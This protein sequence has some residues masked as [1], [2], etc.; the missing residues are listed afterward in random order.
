[1]YHT[2]IPCRHGSRYAQ[3]FDILGTQQRAGPSAPPAPANAGTQATPSAYYVG[4]A[5]PC[6]ACVYAWLIL[7]TIQGCRGCRVVGFQGRRGGGHCTHSVSPPLLKN[8]L[9]PGALGRVF[10][11]PI[12]GPSPPGP[13]FMPALYPNS[14]DLEPRAFA[15]QQA[16]RPAQW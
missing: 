3:S 5:W 14:K 13:G 11:H 6:G 8:S 16:G 9:R 1:M 12:P 15:T 7:A 4:H 2:C 10:T